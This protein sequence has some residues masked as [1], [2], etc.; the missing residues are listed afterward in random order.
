M[1][2]KLEAEL[3]SIAHQILRIK[4]KDDVKQLHQQAQKLYEKLSVLLFAEENFTY[5]NPTISYLDIEEKLEKTSLQEQNLSNTIPSNAVVETIVKLDPIS[6]ESIT[7]KNIEKE[8]QNTFEKESLFADF[9]ITP[10]FEKRTEQDTPVIE[11]KPEFTENI[12]DKKFV[13]V[14]TIST[15]IFDKVESEGFN[16]NDK[17]KKNLT[18]SLNDK[19]AFEKSLFD[20]STEDYNR[21]LSQI[22]TFESLQEAITFINE[23]VKPDYNNWVGQEDLA[24]N[25]IEMATSKF[26]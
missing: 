13:D 14:P 10:I 3:I 20:G 9:A 19:L 15:L 22:N 1:K 5:I 25:F 8:E 26:I 2:K 18:I 11:N 12:S 4:D 17:L 7:I 23:M 6:I 24:S 16:L 21:V